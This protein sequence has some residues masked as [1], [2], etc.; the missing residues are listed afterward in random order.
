MLLI[1][2]TNDYYCYCYCYGYCYYHYHY[3][4]YYYYYYIFHSRQ[5]AALPSLELGPYR[6]VPIKG[7]PEIAVVVVGSRW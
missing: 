3:Y 5:G 2:T 6:A 4:Y 1:A 7:K